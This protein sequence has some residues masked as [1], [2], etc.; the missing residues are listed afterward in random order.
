MT[1]AGERGLIDWGRTVANATEAEIAVSGPVR[2]ELR[3]GLENLATALR[4]K[5]LAEADA[6][7]ERLEHAAHYTTEE[8][9]LTVA[10]PMSEVNAILTAIDIADDIDREDPDLVDDVLRMRAARRRLN[11]ALGGSAVEPP[12]T[13]E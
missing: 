5:R 6:V 3:E 12:T 8:P 11:I 9:L 2:P 7:A 13:T 10:L 4:S 1:T